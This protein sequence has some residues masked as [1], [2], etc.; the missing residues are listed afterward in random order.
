LAVFKGNPIQLTESLYKKAVKIEPPKHLTMSLIKPSTREEEKMEN[1]Y[2]VKPNN[3]NNGHSSSFNTFK[4][5]IS[6]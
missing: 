2:Q 1:V 6:S 4:S 5:Q 3:T